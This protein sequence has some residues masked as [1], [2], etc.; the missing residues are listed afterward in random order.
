[1]RRP[2]SEPLIGDP[3]YSENVAEEHESFK[4]KKLSKSGI[5]GCGH[6]P[7][8]SAGECLS[9]ATNSSID[10]LY[11]IIPREPPLTYD[12]FPTPINAL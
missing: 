2:K 11:T 12:Q 6:V 4:V 1:M 5:N 10:L 9:K 8:T 3:S 7:A